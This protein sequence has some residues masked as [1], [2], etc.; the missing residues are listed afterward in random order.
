MKAV[1]STGGKQYLVSDNEVLEV[2]K[3]PAET[4]K[5][6]LEPLLVIDGEKVHV[7]TPVVKGAKVTA[8]VMGEVKG[9]KIKVLKF[10]AKKREKTLTGH[11]QTYS[12]IKITKI[13]V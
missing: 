11:R 10:K 7:G 1:I 2:E 6:E 12:Q 9:D 5:L 13:T 4:N 8:E 3:V